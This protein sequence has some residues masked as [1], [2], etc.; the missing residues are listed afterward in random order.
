MHTRC[1]DAPEKVV[2][3]I[4]FLLRRVRETDNL[5]GYGAGL[6]GCMAQSDR[7]ASLVELQDERTAPI[8]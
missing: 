6:I 1:M 8:L 2:N 4:W 7:S 5:P 3:Y